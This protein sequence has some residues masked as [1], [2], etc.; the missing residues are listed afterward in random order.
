MKKV[1]LLMIVAISAVLLFSCS[2]GNSPSAYVTEYYK[3]MQKG[4]FKKAVSLINDFESAEES[5][6]L[7]QKLEA[8]KEEG[9]KIE[10]FEIVSVEM[11]EDGNSADVTVKTVTVAKNGEEPS[12]NEET[13]TVYKDENGNWNRMEL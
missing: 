13:L 10:S 11:S 9:F 1:L 6:F 3:A 7:V 12:E 5:D 2:N 8:Q 4:D